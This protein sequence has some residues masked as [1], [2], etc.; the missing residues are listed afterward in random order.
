MITPYGRYRWSRLPFGLSVS[1]EIF[2]KKLTEALLGLER[3]INVAD[4]IVIVGCVEKQD[5][6]SFM[7]HCI[8]VQGIKP[9]IKKIKAILEMKKPENSQEAR[10]LCGMVQY[11]SKFLNNLAEVSQPLRELTKKDCNFRW[12]EKCE[13]A[14]NMIKTMITNTPVL[15]FY[16]PDKKLE[17]QVDSSQHGLG[18]VL[19]Q[20]GQPIEFASRALTPTEKRWAQIEKELLAWVEGN[21]LHI[22]DTLSRLCNQEEKKVFNIFQTHVVDIPDPM[23]QEMKKNLHTAHIAYDGMMRRA[24]Q[25][26]FWPGMADEIKQMAE[27]CSACQERKPINQRETLIQHDEL[28][29]PWEK[30]GADLMEVDGRQSIREQPSPRSYK[31]KGDNGGFYI[32]NRYHIR[33]RKTILKDTD[34]YDGNVLDDDDDN[35]RP[36]FSDNCSQHSAQSGVVSHVPDN[37]CDRNMPART[38]T[39]ETNRPVW[40]RDYDMY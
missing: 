3:C 11:L 6:I 27:T 23:R 19:M 36:D 33:P 26:M 12:T 39:R 25:T 35:E 21:S 10:K 16:N 15:I 20:E 22:A 38:S 34:V 1:G 31:I 7:G 2:Q 4:D 24:R 30:V 28:N 14:F 5:Q 8:S 29:V 40:H 13:E 17:I 18:A 37:N 9:D 32:R